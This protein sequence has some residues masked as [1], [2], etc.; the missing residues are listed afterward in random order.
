VR[1]SRRRYSEALGLHLHPRQRP[2]LGSTVGAVMAAGGLTVAEEEA[3]GGL[4]AGA[5][6]A[7]PGLTDG[8]MAAV[9]RGSIAGKCRIF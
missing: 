1:Q 5:V 9:V 6:V 4:T 7:V 2:V 3:G 8:I